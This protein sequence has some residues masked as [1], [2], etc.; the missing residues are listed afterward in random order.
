MGK[1]RIRRRRYDEGLAY[2][3]RAAENLKA[4]LGDNHYMT[5]DCFYEIA[6]EMLRKGEMDAAV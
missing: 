3:Q 5:G 1:V 2:L 4:T 6:L